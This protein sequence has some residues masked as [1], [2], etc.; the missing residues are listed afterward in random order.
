MYTVDFI[1]FLAYLIIAGALIRTIEMH[2]PDSW[3]GRALGVV[4]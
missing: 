2:F 4:Y 1:K 3:V